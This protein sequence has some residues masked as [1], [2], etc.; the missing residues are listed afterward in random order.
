[1]KITQS[2]D[3]YS[4]LWIATTGLSV[5]QVISLALRGGD[6]GNLLNKL[7]LRVYNRTSNSVEDINLITFMKRLHDK[8]FP[9][10]KISQRGQVTLDDIVIPAKVYF[11]IRYHWMLSTGQAQNQYSLQ[12][13]SIS[14]NSVATTTKSED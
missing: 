3:R 8:M 13:E 14:P 7:D 1:M 9:N 12:T 11:F 10:L 2:N 5:P 6:A 4:E